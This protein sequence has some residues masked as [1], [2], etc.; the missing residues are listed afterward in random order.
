MRFTLPKPPHGWRALAWEISIVFTGV[1]LALGG[2]RLIQH[3][4]WRQEARQASMAIK[5]ELAEHRLAAFER[6]AVQPCL[7]GQLKALHD[8]LSAHQEG[9][10]AG[11]PMVVSQRTSAGAQQ[12][13][14]SYA[15]RSPEPPWVDEAWQI[16]RFTGALNHLPSDDVSRYARVYRLSNRYLGTQDE[17]NAAAARFNVLAL[18][19]W[20]D[21]KSRIELLGAL[22]QADHANAYLELG[23]RQ[24]LEFLQPLL[25]DLPQAEV[26]KAVADRMATQRAFRGRCVQPLK[27]A[28]DR[29]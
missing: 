12:R 10:W 20:I 16:A 27:L 2:E 1:V 24:Q 17:E 5:A 3:H 13:A 22:T 14:L 11:M 4:N 7:K 6:L 29:G 15:Y 23:A 28:R 8:K 26:D 9:R 18:D 21:A 25:N 19:G